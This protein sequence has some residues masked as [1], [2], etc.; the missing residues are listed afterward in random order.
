MKK[1][2]FTVAIAA[3]ALATISSCQKEAPVQEEFKGYPCTIEVPESGLGDGEETKLT[4]GGTENRSM[5]WQAGDKINVFAADGTS[6]GEFVATTKTSSNKWTFT[7]YLKNESDVPTYIFFP[8]QEGA[9]CDESGNITVDIPTVQDGSVNNAIFAGE[10]DSSGSLILKQASAVI[11][12]TIPDDMTDIESIRFVAAGDVQLAGEYTINASTRAWKEVDGK[13]AVIV[14]NSDGSAL[15]PGDK[16]IFFRSCS[17][18][19]A[20]VFTKTT[21]TTKYAA[22]ISVPKKEGF[23]RG[24]RISNFGTVKNLK[25][26]ENAL[27]GVFSVSSTKLA[28]FA[29]GNV[30]YDKSADTWSMY[31]S[32]T[33]ALYKT[34]AS[35]YNKFDYFKWND[36]DTPGT[37]NSRTAWDDAGDW[38]AKI[39]S[40]WAV[41]SATDLDYL[42]K[43]TIQ[44]GQAWAPLRYDGKMNAVVFY[45]D[46]YNGEFFS[47]A[48][49]NNITPAEAEALEADG[50]LILLCRGNDGGGTSPASGGK[51]FYWTSTYHDATPKAKA[52]ILDPAAT[53]P[54][55]SIGGNKTSL[56]FN[57][58][59]IH[60]IN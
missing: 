12:V 17:P 34:Y 41:P 45:P 10:L 42:Y 21:G 39:G 23:Y 3:A 14:R 38:A 40:D 51:G 15:A 4:I 56:G 18:N 28:L 57:V 35:G 27:G 9:T 8:Y 59:L 52:L 49:N 31:T 55:L 25:W 58:R 7:G 29:G 22:A 19:A 16:Y 36:A 44:V 46:G 48:S 53:T 1:V 2:L 26:I 54:A 6:E 20:L 47:Q 13:S 33:T 5:I 60:Y 32:Q 11:K 50:C 43:R 30:V 37:A 24:D